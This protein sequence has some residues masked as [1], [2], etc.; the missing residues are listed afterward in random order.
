MLRPIFSLLFNTGELHVFLP[1]CSS[2]RVSLSSRPL[3]PFVVSICILALSYLSSGEYPYFVL[4]QPSRKRCVCISARCLCIF[5]LHSFLSL[6]LSRFSCGDVRAG[7]YQ[8]S[9]DNAK[10][11][12]HVDTYYHRVSSYLPYIVR[13]TCAHVVQHTGCNQVALTGQPALN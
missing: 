4:S 5:L 1:A 10:I 9:V 13:S 7:V 12:K 2:Y 8:F 6:F 3:I 11:P